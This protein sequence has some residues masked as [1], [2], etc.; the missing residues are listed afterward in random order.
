MEHDQRPAS[1]SCS[2]ARFISSIIH[3][4]TILLTLLIL[5]TCA[6]IAG[7]ELQIGATNLK[8]QSLMYYDTQQNSLHVERMALTLGSSVTEIDGPARSIEGGAELSWKGDMKFLRGYMTNQKSMS[9]A[10]AAHGLNSVGSTTSP[11]AVKG[12]GSRSRQLG[13]LHGHGRDSQGFGS[14]FG[15]T[16]RLIPTGPD[17]LHN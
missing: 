8:A 3:T 17:P 1:G 7:A 5:S 12:A 9:S 13:G 6:I 11:P 10:D 4:M 14:R 16:Y 15:S 2:S